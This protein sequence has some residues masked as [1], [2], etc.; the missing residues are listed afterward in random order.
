[1]NFSQIGVEDWTDFISSYLPSLVLCI[2]VGV[3]AWSILFLRARR[4]GSRLSSGTVLGAIILSAFIWLTYFAIT[5]RRVFTVTLLDAENNTLAEAA[6]K[7]LFDV[8]L[9]QAVDLAVNK[10]Q[11]DNVRFYACCRIADLLTTNNE[12]TAQSVFI[13]VANAPAIVPY[14]FGTNHLTYGFFTPGYSEGP[15]SVREIIERRLRVLHKS[16]S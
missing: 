14:F 8:D 5:A 3:A 10:H 7:N 15:F 12:N 16:G 9:G 13:K 11:P 1:M 4:K 6:Y 2:F